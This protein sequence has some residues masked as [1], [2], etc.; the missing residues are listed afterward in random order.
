MDL[1]QALASLKK[2]A[3]DLRKLIEALPSPVWLL[4]PDGLTEFRN[5][6]WRRLA[7][8]DEADVGTWLDLA[9]HDDRA[10]CDVKWSDLQAAAR[11]GAI[12]ASLRHADGEYRQ[13]VVNVAPAQDA[14]GIFLGWCCSASHAD[15]DAAAGIEQSE[16]VALLLDA[17]SRL[18]DENE[19]LRED[20]RDL[21]EE[22]PIAY[23]H[24]DIDTRFIRANRAALNML[25]LKP[26][27][28]TGTVGRSLVAAIPDNQRTLEAAFASVRKGVEAT[29]VVLELRR[30]DNGAPVWVQWWSKPSSNGAFTRT[31]ML[32]ISD[33][34]LIARTKAALEFSI[35]AGQVGDWDLDLVRDTSRRSLR[36]DQCFGYDAPIPED[37]W[38][39]EVFLRHVHPGDRERVAS[40]MAA[41]LESSE[42][43]EAEFR[44]IWP[45]ASLHWLIARGRVFAELDGKATR[46]LGVVMD[47]TERKRSE[48]A[49]RETKA[50]LDFALQSTQVGDWDLDLV[51]DDSRRSLRHDQCFGYQEPVLKWGVEEFVQHIHPDDRERVASGMGAAVAA[52]E[53]W[54]AEFRV[55][56]PDGSLHWLFAGGSIYRTLEGRATRMLGIVMDISSRK[57]AELA[58]A[59]LYTDLKASEAALRGSERLARGQVE[60]LTRTLDAVAGEAAPEKL[61][62]HVLR[63]LTEKL[64]AHSVTVWSQDAKTGLIAFEGVLEH[65]RFA[66]RDED[67][68]GDRRDAVPLS[69]IWPCEPVFSTGRPVVLE[70]IRTIAAFRWQERLLA[71]GVVTVLFVPMS[72]AG[73][74]TGMIALRFKA[75]RAFR[76]DEVELAQ[77]LANQAMLSMQV[78]RL[79]AESRQA[80]VIA[81]RNRL[82]RD[83]HDTLAQGFT[84]VIVQLQAAEDARN[85]GLAAESDEH[86]ARA[87]DVARD[88]LQEARRS[89]QALRPLALQDRDLS[90]AL[91]LLFEKMTHGARVQ[92]SVSVVGD[93]PAFP[94][95]WEDN[96]LRIGQEALTNVLRH[97]DAR[98][99]S[100]RLVFSPTGLD[101][102]LQ[103]DGRGFDPSAK[104][105]GFGLLG[106]RERVE[107]M[108]GTF[109]IESSAGKGAIVRVRLPTPTL[110][111]R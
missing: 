65:G 6:A 90:A 37:S 4:A 63:T 15:R 91:S 7:G 109:R 34:V 102:D 96:L 2:P 106:M 108:G 23:V 79:S 18:I 3:P 104:G 76:P 87:A 47:I 69:D 44:V 10:D 59:Q 71:L 26:E 36:H 99:F 25:G 48:E 9:R 58:A 81:E 33:R 67:L 103:D 80:A 16:P 35:E 60:A 30:V 12:T 64:D 101:L 70:D 55:I 83:I 56:W 24:E 93:L 31:M 49:L 110:Q 97:A 100:A 86:L 61:V 57:E 21:Y 107:S 17:F 22:A 14:D 28:V 111:A 5:A 11:N 74:V 38:G 32:D 1:A 77:A 73:R 68:D 98:A 50:A 39:R 40:S 46:M 54:S 75:P 43:W 45:D 89:V 62:E 84:G 105:D 85:Q 29:E 53:D 20:F 72:I 13:V 51:L 42:V 88:S 92:T 19:T 95:D 41:A 94:T 78:A 8:L 82:A 27:Q 52:L 66:G